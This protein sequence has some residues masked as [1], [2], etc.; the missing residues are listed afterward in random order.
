GGAADVAGEEGRGPPG[1]LL[2]DGVRAADREGRVA[3]D[4]GVRPARWTAGSQ[5]GRE[6]REVDAAGRVHADGSRGSRA[7]R[8]NLPG[9]AQQEPRQRRRGELQQERGVPRLRY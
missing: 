6:G 4:A 5:R 7:R 8:G 1:W 9:A 2:G 3:A